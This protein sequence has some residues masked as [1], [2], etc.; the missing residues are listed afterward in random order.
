M[1]I[2]EMDKMKKSDQVALLNVM[3]TGILSE[4]KS[5]RTKG[6][7]QQKM[8]LWIFATSIA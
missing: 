7:R 5:K 4:T 8:N 1:L 2:K 3:K 6:S